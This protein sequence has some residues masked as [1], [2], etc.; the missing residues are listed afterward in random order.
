METGPSKRCD[1]SDRPPHIGCWHNPCSVT[2][3]VNF[4]FFVWPKGPLPFQPLEEAAAQ[5]PLVW[6]RRC[7][8]VHGIEIMASFPGCLAE[9]TSAPVWG[10]VLNCRNE[11]VMEWDPFFS[12]LT[13]EVDAWL[14]PHLLVSCNIL[15]YV[16]D[17]RINPFF[18]WFGGGRRKLDIWDSKCRALQFY[19]S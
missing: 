11:W 15:S 4:C 7:I 16:D 10:R 14:V 18:I 13:G 19:H 12:N 8:K 1:L 2:F 3:S 17:V 9:N 6:M 5:S